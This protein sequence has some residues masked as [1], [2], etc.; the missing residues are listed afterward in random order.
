MVAYTFNSSVF[1]FPYGLSSGFPVGLTQVVR[2]V[3]APSEII[4]RPR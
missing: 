1:I 3:T 4:F 2:A